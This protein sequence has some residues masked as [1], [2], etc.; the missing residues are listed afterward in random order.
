MSSWSPLPAVPILLVLGNPPPNA[1]VERFVPYAALLPHV[2]VMVSNGGFGSVQLAI[3]H[4]VPMV[5]AG[6]SEDKKE[7]TA[8]VGW[9][10]VGINLRTNRPSPRAIA[11]AV[12]RVL[13]EPKFRERTLALQA[14][15]A[16]TSPA[17]AAA[18]LL[19]GLAVKATTQIFH[20]R[21]GDAEIAIPGRSVYWDGVSVGHPSLFGPSDPAKM[22]AGLAARSRLRIWRPLVRSLAYVRAMTAFIKYVTFDCADPRGLSVFLV[23]GH[24]LPIRG[25]RG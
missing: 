17:K 2:D 4:G 20:E 25:R 15:T 10:G 23:T 9:S 5:V 16:D 3:A 18:D 14:Q 7:V 12:E 21:I 8:H 1:V 19:E 13:N 11:E 6:T 24:W 22:G